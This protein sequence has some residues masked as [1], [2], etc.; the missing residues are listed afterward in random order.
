MA[1]KHDLCRFDD[2]QTM[3]VTVQPDGHQTVWVG[4]IYSTT[5][6]DPHDI[7]SVGAFRE[8]IEDN[9]YSDKFELVIV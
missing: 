7:M 6:T 4:N 9:K 5:F 2:Y 1:T 3:V 8:L